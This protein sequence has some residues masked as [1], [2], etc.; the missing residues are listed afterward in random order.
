MFQLLFSFVAVVGGGGGGGLVWG[1]LVGRW[2][3]WGEGGLSLLFSCSLHFAA[4]EFA[5]FGVL[6]VRPKQEF[7][8]AQNGTELYHVYQTSPKWNSTNVVLTVYCIPCVSNQPKMEHHHTICYASHQPK[9]VQYQCSIDCWQYNMCIHLAIHIPFQLQP[10]TMTFSLRFGFQQ[11]N[12]I[13]YFYR[14]TRNK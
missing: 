6:W 2:G 10:Q 9:K 11:N 8:P 7:K 14:N 1:F 4:R 12:E 5:L 3:G 13:V